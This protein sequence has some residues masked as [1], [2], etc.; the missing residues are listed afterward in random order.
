MKPKVIKVAA[1]H[2]NIDGLLGQL[3]DACSEFGVT[4]SSD[5]SY[6]GS[7]TYGFLVKRKSKAKKPPKV[8]ERFRLRK[9]IVGGGIVT[10]TEIKR[11]RAYYKYD[12]GDTGW[13]RLDNFGEHRRYH[14]NKKT[15]A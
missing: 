9:L 5:P 15:K 4:I 10:I 11:G 7:D 1:D 14:K 13:Q 3:I 2:R 12:N 6:K 8:G